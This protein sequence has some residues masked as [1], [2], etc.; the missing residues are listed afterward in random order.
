RLKDDE[1]AISII[2]AILMVALLGF[3]AIVVDIGSLYAERRQLQNG[4]DSAAL[5]VAID[6]GTTTCNGVSTPLGT[7]TSNAN[8]N[9]NDGAT[10]VTQVCGTATG[11]T[12]CS[13][14]APSGSWDCSAVP[15]SG[16]WAT[17]KY[18]QVR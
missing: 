12:A 7:A 4:A 14:A 1:G 13:P 18:V 3:G 15:S 9:A 17:A 6:C 11:L 5:A 10:T 2:V 16:P 8:A